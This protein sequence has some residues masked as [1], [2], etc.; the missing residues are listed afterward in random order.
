MTAKDHLNRYQLRYQPLPE[1]YAPE[2]RHQITALDKETGHGVGHLQWAGNE[3]SGR[4]WDIT[5]RED[6]Q[7]K[8][9]ATAM[10]EK[11]D[12]LAQSSGRRIYSPEHS[13]TRTP[14]GDAWAKKVGG[15]LPDNYYND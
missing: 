5:V 1:K 7:R 6:H 10:Y 9:L 15:S 3:N 12:R 13:E 4:I 14:A 11:A 8:G 2:M